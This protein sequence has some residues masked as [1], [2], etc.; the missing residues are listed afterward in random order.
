MPRCVILTE[1]PARIDSLTPGASQSDV[2]TG[3]LWGHGECAAWGFHE[4]CGSN[5][6]DP[7]ILSKCALAL[8]VVHVGCIGN[9]SRQ[10]IKI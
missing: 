2:T 9:L 6:V 7:V 1:T 10:E 8:V 4:S 5:P 3:R